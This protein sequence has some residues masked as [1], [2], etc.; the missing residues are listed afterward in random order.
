MVCYNYDMLKY[1]ELQQKKSFYHLLILLLLQQVY[2]MKTVFED[3]EGH[4]KGL[5][6][7]YIF[8]FCLSLSLFIPFFLYLNSRPLSMLF[9]LFTAL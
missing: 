5:L 4:K 9:F 7:I 3:K 1:K 8:K 2:I 6:Y